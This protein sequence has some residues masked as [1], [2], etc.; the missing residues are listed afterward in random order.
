M[1]LGG[2]DLRTFSLGKGTLK[3]KKKKIEE[4]ITLMTSDE[5][6][7]KNCRDVIKQ[8]KHRRMLER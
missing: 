3:D 5:K 8:I 1:Q 4:F 2:Y 7:L 6:N